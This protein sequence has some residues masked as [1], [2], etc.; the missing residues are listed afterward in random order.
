MKDNSD[1]L[2]E[3]LVPAEK[4]ARPTPGMVIARGVKAA[5]TPFNM[6]LWVMIAMVLTVAGPFGTYATVDF[7]PRL[8]FWV[9]VVPIS[10]ILGYASNT[11]TR[12]YMRRAHPLMAD[13]CGTAIMVVTFTP[14]LYLLVHAFVVHPGS[15]GPGLPRL[16]VYCA[17]VS[18]CILTARRLIPGIE[19]RNYLPRDHDVNRPR[20]TR[21]LTPHLA[22]EVLR[23]SSQDHFVDVVTRAGTERLR[24]RLADAIDE[25]DGVEGLLVH[26]SHWVAAEAVRGVERDGARVQLRL[27]N[28][29][30]VPVSRTYRA[31]LEAMGLI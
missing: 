28:G 9:L 8:A 1:F 12:H 19:T 5:L 11:V 13:L 16:A 25:M 31:E 17:A 22:G 30:V 29:D 27:V 6:A 10:T 24:L 2:R 18:F 20:L 21:R 7:G 26:R 15:D 23:I 14:P 4:V 3:R